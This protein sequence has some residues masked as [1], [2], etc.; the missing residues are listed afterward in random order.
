MQ[1]AGDDNYRIQNRRIK[2]LSETNVEDFVV[3]SESLDPNK[4]TTGMIC[5]AEPSAGLKK[6]IA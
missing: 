2:P 4:Y 5:P 6:K 3:V 1:G